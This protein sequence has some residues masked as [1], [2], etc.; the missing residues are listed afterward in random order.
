VDRGE[1]NLPVVEKMLSGEGHGVTFSGIAQY[2]KRLG[3]KSTKRGSGER[4][5]RFDED[6]GVNAEGKGGKE[7]VE[8]LAT[9]P[10]F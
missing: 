9:V 3:L 8:S 5:N 1:E 6:I 2:A 4:V 10:R 7:I